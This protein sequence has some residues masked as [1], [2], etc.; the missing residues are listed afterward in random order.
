MRSTSA[1]LII[2]AT[3]TLAAC[4]KKPRGPTTGDGIPVGVNASN[5]SAA[6]N[7]M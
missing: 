1:I 2:A 6:D 3:L 4:Q 7:Q 5:T